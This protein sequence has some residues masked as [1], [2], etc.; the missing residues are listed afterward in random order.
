MSKRIHRTAA[1]ALFCCLAAGA[2]AQ[3]PERTIR[4][5]LTHCYVA[6]EHAVEAVMS[7][8]K[9]L[10]YR[11]KAVVMRGTTRANE[12]GGPLDGAATRCVGTF[13]YL[14]GGFPASEGCCELA[15]SAEVRLL[16]RWDSKAGEGSSAVLAGT[17]RYWGA[18]GEGSFR[19]L[20]PIIPSLEPG[21][22]RSCL[23]GTGE[24]KL[25]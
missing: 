20:P 16:F 5:D 14:G 11:V 2:A 25:P 13:A 3:T 23:R 21:M 12:P 6:E 24:F 10:A 18:S 1:A 7:D 15:T 8:Y 19:V 9:V 17:G 4:Y 22:F